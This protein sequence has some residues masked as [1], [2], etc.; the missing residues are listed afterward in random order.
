MALRRLLSAED[1]AMAWT[2][3]PGQAVG[4]GRQVLMT[5]AYALSLPNLI[6]MKQKPAAWVFRWTKRR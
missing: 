1:I 5:G 3:M 2:D 4:F 6:H